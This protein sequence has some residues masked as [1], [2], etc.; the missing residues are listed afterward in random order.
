M[1]DTMIDS[2]ISV[3]DLSCEG[4][5][6]SLKTLSFSISKGGVHGILSPFGVDASL[7]LSLLA[8]VFLPDSGELSFG[9]EKIEFSST[10]W[11]KKVGYVPKAP[12]FYEKMTVSEILGFVGEARGVSSELCLRQVSEAIA[13][14]DLTP[15]EDRLTERLSSAEKKRLSLAAALI[16]NPS[17]LLFDDPTPEFFDLIAMLGKHKTVILGGGDLSVMQSLCEDV[18]ILSDGTLVANGS[19]SELESALSE[20][21]DS[22]SLAEVFASLELLSKENGKSRNAIFEG[23]E[24]GR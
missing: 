5:S 19:F 20:R 10:E 16:G 3:K 1:A 15:I 14:L 7:L 21:E 22:H 17:I 8:G 2:I 4:K 23:E 9:G 18:V 12:E 6:T 11:K 13:L 24:K